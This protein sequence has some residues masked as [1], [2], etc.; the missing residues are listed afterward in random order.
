MSAI[1]IAAPPIETLADL[2][3]RLGNIPTN[4]IR[5]QPYPGT[6]TETDLL[7]LEKRTGRVCELIDGV[8]V[9]KPMAWNE[10]SLAGIVQTLLNNFILPRNLGVVTGEQGTFRLFPGLVRIPDVAFTSWDRLPGRKR[11]TQ[12][13]P[14]V[15]PDLAIEVLSVSNTQQEMDRKRSEYFAADVRL[16]WII[17]PVARIVSVFTSPEFAV[18]LEESE[19][20]DGGDVL[21]G[22]QI[23]LKDL[24]AELDRHG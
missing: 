1:S 16:V 15:T 11:P 13:I 2:L 9:E 19:I 18:T 21:P 24:F 12:P 7:D 3:D 14:S 8:L 10:S 6:A 4:R 22:F 20:L 23:P 17:D 5:W